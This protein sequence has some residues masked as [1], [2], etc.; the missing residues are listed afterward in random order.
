LSG[1]GFGAGAQL[2]MVVSGSSVSPWIAP[3]PPPMT[4]AMPIGTNSVRRMISH[5]FLILELGEISTSPE[6]LH[7][8]IQVLTA[9]GA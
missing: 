1:Q 9:P 2:A 7:E 6:P 4:S 3:S 8:V 5:L